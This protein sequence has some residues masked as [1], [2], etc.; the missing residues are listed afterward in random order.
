MAE[1]A[2][3]NMAEEVGDMVQ[4]VVGNS[5]ALVAAI[6]LVL[7]IVYMEQ[8]T[9]KG[10]FYDYVVQPVMKLMGGFKSQPAAVPNSPAT[11]AA[12]SVSEPPRRWWTRRPTK[13]GSSTT[14]RSCPC[15]RTQR[16]G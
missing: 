3:S 5:Q 7:L 14:A 6:V 2:L 9:F 8:A 16:R 13:T 1:D 11:S 10:L 4:D 12:D 15:P